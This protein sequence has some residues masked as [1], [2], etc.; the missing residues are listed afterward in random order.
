M[1]S[2]AVAFNMFPAFFAV[3]LTALSLVK[4]SSEGEGGQQVAMR[5]SA[6]LPGTPRTSRDLPENR[7]P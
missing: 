2:Q 7:S 1:V 4:S 5:I 6:V 3:L